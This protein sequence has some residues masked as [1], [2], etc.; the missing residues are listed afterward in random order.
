MG[1]YRVLSLKRKKRYSLGLTAR[2]TPAV[3]FSARWWWLESCCGCYPPSEKAPALQGG[4]FGHKT[5]RQDESQAENV[6]DWIPRSKFS[7]AIGV[8]GDTLV[9]CLVP[10]LDFHCHFLDK[11]MQD[12]TLAFAD[13]PDS[14][15]LKSNEFTGHPAAPVRLS[16]STMLRMVRSGQFPQPIHLSPRCRVWTAGQ[17][18]GWLKSKAAI[19]G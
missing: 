19:A 16:E 3:V 12:K 1:F 6:R 13:I 14:A 7:K 8:Y 9:R 2:E 18:R 10:A 5:T 15:F 4:G 17:I 11:I